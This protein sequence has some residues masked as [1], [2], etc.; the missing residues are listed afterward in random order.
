MLGYIWTVLVLIGAA[1]ILLS[2]VA[3]CRATAA[4]VDLSMRGAP[5][6]SDEERRNDVLVSM[7]RWR[8]AWRR[9]FPV[10]PPAMG[11]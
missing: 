6:H 3:T 10:G 11:W 1:P 9:R 5:R 4:V 7:R 8:R 2:L